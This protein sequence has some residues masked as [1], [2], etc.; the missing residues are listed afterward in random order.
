MTAAAG[1]ETKIGQR[2]AEYRET[3]KLTQE[4][5]AERVGVSV[6]SISRVERGVT[7]PSITRLASISEALGI[8]LRDLL[9]LSQG[10]AAKDKALDSLHR[11]LASRTLAEIE[12][13]HDVAKCIFRKKTTRR[14]RKG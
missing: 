14:A 1:L 4:K 6:E 3:V 8:E 10:K 13:V 11:Y 5:L 2:V 9:T 12:V 7:L